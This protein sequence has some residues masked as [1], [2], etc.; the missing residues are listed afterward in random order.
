MAHRFAIGAIAYAAIAVA[1]FGRCA[2]ENHQA[3]VSVCQRDRALCLRLR[4]PA[5]DGVA[6]GIFW[7]LYWSWEAWQSAFPE[8]TPENTN[9]K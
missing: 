1:T 9:G 7:P 3:A 2:A 5:I 4:P 6:A 8:P